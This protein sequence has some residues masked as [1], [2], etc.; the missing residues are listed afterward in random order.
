MDAKLRTGSLGLEMDPG[1][2]WDIPQLTVTDADGARKVRSKGNH[3]PLSS[4]RPPRPQGRQPG[5]GG[6]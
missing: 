3:S 1:C 4:G 6:S 2:R 5:A